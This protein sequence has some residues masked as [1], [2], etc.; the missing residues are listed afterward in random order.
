MQFNTVSDWWY[1]THTQSENIPFV[2]RSDIGKS[3]N[4]RSDIDRLCKVN[5][6][7]FTSLQE[8]GLVE[9]RTKLARDC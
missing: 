1:W 3:A 9:L 2:V 4:L 8:M 7:G 6:G 5:Q